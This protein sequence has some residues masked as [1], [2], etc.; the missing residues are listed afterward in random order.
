MA[1][2][3]F[4]SAMNKDNGKEDD[5]DL[6]AIRR[7]DEYFASLERSFNPEFI[8]MVKERYGDD[9]DDISDDTA[10]DNDNN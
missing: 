8:K 3:G 6:E 5:A 9:S 7:Q 4:E 1:R 10:D 2:I